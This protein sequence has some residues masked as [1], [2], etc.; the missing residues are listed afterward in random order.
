M[1]IVDVSQ[2]EID[3]SSSNRFVV[4]SICE[5]DDDSADID[6][7]DVEEK[8]FSSLVCDCNVVASEYPKFVESTVI[9]SEKRASRKYDDVVCTCGSVK[10]DDANTSDVDSGSVV[11]DIVFSPLSVSVTESLA[12]LFS[13][14]KS[15]AFADVVCSVI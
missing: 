1:V 4:N 9:K 11:Y 12:E 7:S 8:L 15:S 3:L 14:I 2:S 6:A 10:Y 13:D 5:D